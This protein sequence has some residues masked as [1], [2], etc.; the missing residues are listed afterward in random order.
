MNFKLSSLIITSFIF[1][2]FNNL[3]SQNKRSIEFDNLD[4][5]YFKWKDFSFNHPWEKIKS[6]CSL[7][8]IIT[9][10]KDFQDYYCGDISDTTKSY[11]LQNNIYHEFN[12]VW[13]DQ[14]VLH[15]SGSS[16]ARPRLNNSSLCFIKQLSDS[17]KAKSLYQE[18][19]KVFKMKYGNSHTEY[20]GKYNEPNIIENTPSPKIKTGHERAVVDS[21]TVDIGYLSDKCPFFL[22][23]QTQWIGKNNIYLK[24]SYIQEN[25]LI[26][27]IVSEY[28][29]KIFN[30][31]A[32]NWYN[33]SE[34]DEKITTAFKEFDSRSVYKGLK[35]GSLKSEVQKLVNFKKTDNSREYAVETEKYKKWLDITFD[36][37]HMSFN[38]KNQ[39]YDVMLSI[40]EYA[41]KDYEQLLNELIE[42]FGSP[43]GFKEINNDA[44]FTTWLGKNIIVFVMRSNNR[45]IDI[46]IS[47]KRLNDWSV[48]DKLY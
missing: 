33:E 44:E 3:F 29:S 42:L 22:E 17:N 20:L 26:I 41:E 35:F 8:K 16:G 7:E 2:Y 28:S 38:K 5:S 40:D 10:K 24:L 43:K 48:T 45:S 47:Y 9:Y 39:F 13:F 27:F 11:L 34:Y 32:R 15:I 37:C 1:F 36:H 4:N 46:D 21:V 14:V 25:N 18:M 30:K 6:V 23:E 12:N 31:N 19:L